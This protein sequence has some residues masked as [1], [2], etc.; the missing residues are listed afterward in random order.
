MSLIAKRYTHYNEFIK[1][2]KD[3]DK[4]EEFTISKEDAFTRKNTDLGTIKFS[5]KKDEKQLEKPVEMYNPSLSLTYPYFVNQFHYIDKTVNGLDSKF[6]L[7]YRKE[8]TRSD[9]FM[10]F[11]RENPKEGDYVNIRRTHTRDVVKNIANTFLKNRNVDSDSMLSNVGQNGM[12]SNVDSDSMPS[13]VGQNGMPSNVE[14]NGTPGGKKSKRAR[15]N[16]RK[17]NKK[18]KNTRRK[19]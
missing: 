19:K 1:E 9:A 8:K 4:E 2:N 12:P 14:K 10:L 13:N 18:S 7:A 17:K 11:D 15:S 5:F 16:K 3:L 6:V